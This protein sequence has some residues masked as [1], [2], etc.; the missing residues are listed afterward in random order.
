MRDISTG[1]YKKL[2]LICY[3]GIL[4]FF[5]FLAAR[6]PVGLYGDSGQFIEMHMH[7]EP[8]YPLFLC[9]FRTIFGE[10]I[11]L[12]IVSW[13][14]NIINAMAAI[15]FI[16]FF[17]KQILSSPVVMVLGSL[18]MLVPH[19][20]TPLFSQ[21]GIVLSC[22]I[23]NESIALPLFYVFLIFTIS[24]AINGKLINLVLS[25]LVALILS[26]TRG[27]MMICLI[28]WMIVVIVR[29]IVLK[30]KWYFVAIPLVTLALLMKLRSGLSAGYNYLVNGV[31]ASD[32]CGN[33][34]LVTNIL[35]ASDREAG[36][37]I[38]NP[39]TRDLFYEIYDKADADGLIYHSAESGY[40]EAIK[41]LENSHDNLKFNYILQTEQDYYYANV[42]DDYLERNLFQEETCKD[43]VGSIWGACI[44][45]WIYRYIGLA[46][47]GVTRSVAVVTPYTVIPAVLMVFFALALSIYSVIKR[48][49]VKEA[50]AML[51]ILMMLAA[52]ACATAILIMCL[53]RYMIYCFAPFYIGLMTLLMS[54][55]KEWKEKK[56]EL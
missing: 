24:Y 16:R 15:A 26:M 45:R 7:R 55:Y 19:I 23:M 5:V 43:I 1:D 41:H 27:S 2:N 6:F 50:I 46:I 32:M 36:E 21:S 33:M 31:A 25:A 13:T 14:Q 47:N 4:A 3:A 40:Y 37:L 54:Y 18:V 10:E 34:N 11:Y 9:L 56:N 29:F 49:H 17:N 48:K 52:N 30:K 28:A 42:G 51:I 35:Y 38:E 22:G 8:V 39:V 12:L 53:S 20:M 44:G